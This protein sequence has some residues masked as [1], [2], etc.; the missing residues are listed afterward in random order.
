MGVSSGWDLRSQASA[1]RHG[2]TL[3]ITGVPEVPLKTSFNSA[4][5]F[6]PTAGKNWIAFWVFLGPRIS[7]VVEVPITTLH[8][9]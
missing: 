2:S 3:C 8:C 1:R 5:L 7:Y 9:T 4:N 6:D